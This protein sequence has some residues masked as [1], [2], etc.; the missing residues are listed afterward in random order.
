MSDDRAERLD[1]MWDALNA[2]RP[3]DAGDPDYPLLADLRAAGCVVAPKER[4]WMKTAI[5]AVS[6]ASAR[7][8]AGPMPIQFG[9]TGL[10]EHEPAGRE[11]PRW[12]AVAAVV[13]LLAGF[14]GVMNRDGI[15]RRFA[16]NPKPTAAAIVAPANNATPGTD[17]RATSVVEVSPATPVSETENTTSQEFVATTPRCTEAS[18]RISVA[19]SLDGDVEVTL[20][21]I[22][23]QL[24]ASLQLPATL[25]PLCVVSGEV[26]FTAP[27][28]G[29]EWLPADETMLRDG[30]AGI[31]IR[32]E[33]SE[34]ASVLV[35][36]AGP[37]ARR[38]GPAA[39][40]V[41]TDYG[42]NRALA[43]GAD[44]AALSIRTF[45]L[46][47]GQT[48]N[49]DTGL[50]GSALI[51][52]TDGEL[53]VPRI[54][55]QFGFF[56]RRHDGSALAIDDW[57][58]LY[59]EQ[60][61]I[62]LPQGLTGQLNESAGV[63]TAGKQGANGIVLTLDPASATL[64]G[65][66]PTVAV[67]PSPE[68][69]TPAA[70]ARESACVSP[71]FNEAD[72]NR[73]FGSSGALATSEAAA[74]TARFSPGQG[75]PAPEAMVQDVTRTMEQY[76]ACSEPGD[77]LRWFGLQSPRF[78][79]LF[80]AFADDGT[81]FTYD[82]F[83]KQVND[84]SFRSLS[85]PGAELTTWDVRL[86]ADG[87][88]TANVEIDGEAAFVT[89]VEDQGRWL[90]DD[91]DDTA[92]VGPAPAESAASD[93]D[94]VATVAPTSVPIETATVTAELTSNA[95]MP[96]CDG[97]VS[98]A[99]VDANQQL[100]YSLVGLTMQPGTEI[101][102][103]G[104]VGLVCVL[105][106][107]I[108]IW[109]PWEDSS[110]EWLAPSGSPFDAVRQGGVRVEGNE[111]AI[112][113]VGLIGPEARRFAIPQGVVV[114][115]YGVDRLDELG[116][117]TVAVKIEMFDLLPGEGFVLDPGASGAAIAAVTGGAFAENPAY[118]G[119]HGRAIGRLHDGT[120]PLID[121][122]NQEVGPPS[123][124]MSVAANRN[125]VAYLAGPDGV[126]GFIIRVDPDSAMLQG[127]DATPEATSSADVE[128]P[129]IEVG[130]CTAPPFSEEQFND[131]YVSRSMNEATVIA[132]FSLPR[133]S[134]GM[135][136]P[137]DPA[138]IDGVTETIRQFFACADRKTV[139]EFLGLLDIALGS[140]FGPAVLESD[141]GSGTPVILEDM[142]TWD[143]WVAGITS[144]DGIV[145]DSGPVQL[146]LVWDVR[147]QPDGRATALVEMNGSA[148]MVT[149]RLV[150]GRWLISDI[151]E[152]AIVPRAPV[153][154]PTE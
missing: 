49:V 9:H 138:T 153:A 79:G 109:Y 84:G 51:A 91:V 117:E 154:T 19:P 119:A 124:G 115:D 13:V 11:W 142:A 125:V 75:D 93:P 95:A 129:V 116:A 53:I 55:V 54:D 149:F 35:G 70:T 41:V 123:A 85:T 96:S 133:L 4:V 72:F 8:P 69:K 151:D 68:P 97:A 3:V 132:I 139:L 86:Q 57:E 87:R 58:A 43:S 46:A 31:E 66:E 150:D 1:A 140:N 128:R 131:W 40:V 21:G 137:A 44:R 92:L 114:V 50:E 83:V 52:V 104:T 61:E 16:G 121:D 12:L 62:V 28:F 33:G 24:G 144:S 23:L 5:P 113:L 152:F 36:L 107:E 67:R 122:I 10:T 15:E 78:I 63:F 42:M 77:V 29:G 110:G 106:G 18:A 135:G 48:L 111:P 147:I 47:S 32:A 101:R 134:P 99:P 20:L 88:V 80:F 143:E 74:R 146:N 94:E 17:E 98:R 90:I 45:Q 59:P 22:T 102:F 118:I 30:R 82:D 25:G 89:F 105:S 39:G 6:S 103:E 27:E 126:S 34:P 71:E 38:I 76:V 100:V 56:G 60:G 64:R 136:E 14:A 81:D 130:E 65:Y 120:Y 26:A 148:L 7:T 141:D 2:G 73:W 108:S 127:Y 37:G 112:V 145:F